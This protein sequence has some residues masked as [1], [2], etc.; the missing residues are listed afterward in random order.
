MAEILLNTNSP[1][2]LKIFWKG[3]PHDADA[4]PVVKIYDVTEDPAITPSIEPG[5]LLRTISSTKVETDE[6][7]YEAY[8]PLDLT[9]RNRTLKFL[10]RSEEHTSELQSH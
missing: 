5:Q 4:N 3:Q 1:V 9:T 2:K 6:G 10:W 8:P 7:V